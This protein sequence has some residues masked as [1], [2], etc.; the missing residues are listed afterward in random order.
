MSVVVATA[1]ASD[2]EQHVDSIWKAC[3]C[4]VPA[5]MTWVVLYAFTT[6]GVWLNV[7]AVA[8]PRLVSS[9]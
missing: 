5:A 3:N 2:A 9:W 4:I 6:D 7:S 1:L 8:G